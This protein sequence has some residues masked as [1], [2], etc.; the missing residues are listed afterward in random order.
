MTH[1][2]VLHYIGNDFDVTFDGSKSAINKAFFAGEYKDVANLAAENMGEVF[3]RT[4]HINW[5]WVD[6]LEAANDDDEYN[7]PLVKS[8]RSTSVGD[9]IFDNTNG[10][11]YAIARTGYTK[12]S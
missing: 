9:I 4:N 7:K 12:L 8:A 6:A 5:N 11:T 3:E 1:Y 2:T 10:N